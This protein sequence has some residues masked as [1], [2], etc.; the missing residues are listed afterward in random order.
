MTARPRPAATPPTPPGR[1]PLLLAV[2]VSAGEPGIAGSFPHVTGTRG[3]WSPYFGARTFVH[4]PCFPMW[5]EVW[6]R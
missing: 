3:E 4:V 2:A 5:A 6:R 1:V